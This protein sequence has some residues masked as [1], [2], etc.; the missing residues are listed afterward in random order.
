MI[1]L[2]PLLQF[3]F[4]FNLEPMALTPTFERFFFIFFGVMVIFGAVARIMARHKK[5]D[6]LLL[7]VY[8]QIGRMFLTMGVLGLLIFFFTFEE[9]QFFGARFWFLIWGIGL[10][11]WIV[12]IILAAKKIPQKREEYAKAKEGDQYLPRKKRK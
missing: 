12:M 8:R 11:V 3:D 9:I 1:Q 7:Q 6:R 10:I 2:K 5:D 4:W